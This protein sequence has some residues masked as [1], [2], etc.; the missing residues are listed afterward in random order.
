M[1][2][3]GPEAPD[4]GTCRG[5]LGNVDA[6]LRDR[7]RRMTGTDLDVKALRLLPYLMSAA[8]DRNIMVRRLSPDELGLIADLDGRGLVWTKFG[9]GDKDADPAAVRATGGA[10]GLF[11]IRSHRFQSL[12]S[13]ILYAAFSGPLGLSAF[14][15]MD[16]PDGAGDEGKGR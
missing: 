13:D 10:E 9:P 1:D 3:K 4:R 2:A 11:F 15:G 12:V 14:A 6:G 5:M 16:D 7:W 8:M